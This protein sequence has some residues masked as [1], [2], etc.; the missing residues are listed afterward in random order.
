MPRLLKV[1]GLGVA[2]RR[3][4]VE[5]AGRNPHEFRTLGLRVEGASADLLDMGGTAKADA[6][7][8]FD[9]WRSVLEFLETGV[10][11]RTYRISHFAACLNIG[12]RPTHTAS[13]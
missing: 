4:H 9:V 11:D 13:R 7:A 2:V 10:K 3:T 8:G 12:T 5:A 1:T 6:E